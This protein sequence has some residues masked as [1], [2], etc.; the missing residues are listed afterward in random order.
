MFKRIFSSIPGLIV[1]ASFAAAAMKLP[2]FARGHDRLEIKHGR[3]HPDDGLSGRAHSVTRV[4]GDSII[5]KTFD[6][7]AG[8][9]LDVD[10]KTGGEI[11]VTGWEKDRIEV[12]ATLEDEDC[13]DARISFEEMSQGLRISSS[14]ATRRRNQSCDTDFEIMV[15]EKQSLRFNTMGGD[16]RVENVEGDIRGKTMGGELDLTRIKGDLSLTTMGGDITLT[17]SEVE[18]SVKTMGGKVLLEDVV[19]GVK[20]ESMGGNVVY[21]RVSNKKGVPGSDEVR[22]KTMGGDINVDDAPDG[23]DV[24]TMG[25]GIHIKSAG[26]HVK[27]LTM[28]GEIEIEEIDG[29]VNATTMGGDVDVRMI[30]DPNK[31]DRDVSLKSYGG[32][33]TL[34]V[35]EGLSMDLDIQLAFTRKHEGDYRIESDFPMQKKTST[36]WEY[37]HGDPRK[38]IYGTGTVHG[39][40]HRIV[41]E[42][43]NGN[44]YLKKGSKGARSGS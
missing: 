26:K 4:T 28:G 21:R 27:A 31:G 1:I 25:G 5:R 41:I 33:I 29:S 30:G 43:I 11:Q 10:L 15:P 3:V 38:F 22:I 19:G 17:K 37:G 8:Q 35:P 44:V 23:A 6:S 24:H 14:Y 12:V 42:T 32:D 7:K 40:K 36:E 2:A 18:G 20:G 9:M 13:E 39:G 16:I 34:I